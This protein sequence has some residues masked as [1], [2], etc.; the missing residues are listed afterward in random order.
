MESLSQQALVLATKA[1][2]YARSQKWEE[3]TEAFEKSI[4]QLEILPYEATTARLDYVEMLVAKGELDRAPKQLDLARQVAD[5]L[6][7]RGLLKRAERLLQEISAK[8]AA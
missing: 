1:F 7:A 6:G 4:P 3:A 8:Q 2:V 5:D